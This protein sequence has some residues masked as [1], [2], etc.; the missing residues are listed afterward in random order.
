M[1]SEEWTD[2]AVQWFSLLPGSLSNHSEIIEINART[3][4]PLDR[5]TANRGRVSVT[6]GVQLHL[7]PSNRRCI[8]NELSLQTKSE[9]ILLNRI[10]STLIIDY[11]ITPLVHF[12]VSGVRK[13]TIHRTRKTLMTSVSFWTMISPLTLVS[14]QKLSYVIWAVLI[15]LRARSFGIDLE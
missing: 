14:I 1:P 2:S 7:K 13:T 6:V 9:Q 3:W 8:L 15:R 10:L 12:L 11:Y 4:K 5:E